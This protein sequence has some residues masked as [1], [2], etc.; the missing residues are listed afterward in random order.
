[1][2]RNHTALITMRAGAEVSATARERTAFHQQVNFTQQTYTSASRLDTLLGGTCVCEGQALD[3]LSRVD[4]GSY[5]A[6][7]QGTM[8]KSAAAPFER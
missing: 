6:F 3:K 2:A 1:M 5:V 4:L 7:R 8:A